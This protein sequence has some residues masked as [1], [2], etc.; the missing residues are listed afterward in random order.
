MG[1]G[2]LQNRAGVGVVS[3]VLP[4]RGGGGGGVAMLKGAQQVL[5]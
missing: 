5:T 3:E 2:W 4:L 1:K